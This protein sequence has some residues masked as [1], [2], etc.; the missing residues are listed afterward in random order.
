MLQTVIEKNDVSA[1]NEVESEFNQRLIGD[2]LKLRFS[3]LDD[4]YFKRWVIRGKKDG[5]ILPSAANDQP[6]HLTDD[7]QLEKDL[8]EKYYQTNRN[9][10]DKSIDDITNVDDTVSRGDSKLSDSVPKAFHSSMQS[11]SSRLAEDPII[12]EAALHETENEDKAFIEQDTSQTN[13]QSKGL[14]S[15]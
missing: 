1:K 10:L 14:D 2:S 11:L 6:N 12:N 7:N 5:S 8:D 9:P 13:V 15:F 3:R 4:L